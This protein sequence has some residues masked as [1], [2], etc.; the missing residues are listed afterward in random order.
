MKKLVFLFILFSLLVQADNTE[1]LEKLDYELY[2]LEKE[3]K[4]KLDSSNEQRNFEASIDTIRDLIKDIV[5]DFPDN[6][7]ESIM[8]DMDFDV[9][10]KNIKKVKFKNEKLEIIESV[11][12]KNYFYLRQVKKLL[13]LFTTVENREK[14]KV[15]E[16]TY[17]KVSDKE[18]SYEILSYFSFESDK[19]KIREIIENE[20][21]NFTATEIIDQNSFN[22]LLKEIKYASRNSQKLKKIKEKK[23]YYLF[24]VSQVKSILSTFTINSASLKFEVLEFLYPKIV[25]KQNDYRLLEEF[26]FERDRKKAKEIMEK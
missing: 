14:V 15:V 21:E 19:E 2:K 3:Y 9:L 10:I 20:S 7:K 11:S 16:Y 1:S 13:S 5:E 17:P 18:K 25:D 23:L 4:E 6:N 24:T 8:S 26:D 22:S 12:E